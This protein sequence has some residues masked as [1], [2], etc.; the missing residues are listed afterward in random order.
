MKFRNNLYLL[1]FIQL[2]LSSTLTP[3]ADIE[4]GKQKAAMCVGCHERKS[5]FSEKNC[6]L[7]LLDFR[8]KTFRGFV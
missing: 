3:A 6:S 2:G 1:L 7:V 4:A 8:R 5:Y